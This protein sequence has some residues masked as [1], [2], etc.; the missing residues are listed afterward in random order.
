MKTTYGHLTYCTNI[1]P[2]ETWADHFAQLKEQVPGIKK[3]I[4]PDQSFGIGLRLSNTASLELRKEEN[5][6]EFQQWLKEQ[7]CYVFT[8]NG[9]PYGGFHNTTVK[10]KVHQPDWTT[11]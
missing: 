2:G 3:A 1:H 6:K 4:S 7:D 11:A 8:M 10:D 5:L 9:F